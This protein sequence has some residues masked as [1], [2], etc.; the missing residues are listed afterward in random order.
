MSIFQAFSALFGL[1]MMY[2]VFL[3][4][5]KNTLTT[6]EYSF[7]MSLWMLF[8]AFAI[9]PDLLL[10]I[11]QAIRFARVFDLLV[12]ISFMI[13]TLLVFFTYLSHKEIKRKIE[14]LVRQHAITHV[15]KK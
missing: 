2:V 4:Y 10:G 15:N 12:V 9:F 6:M 7:W 8:I 5:R 1:F 3:H 14:H 11:T 13:I